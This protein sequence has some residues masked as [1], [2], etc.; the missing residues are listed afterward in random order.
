MHVYLD[1][2]VH[3][4]AHLRVAAHLYRDS[5]RINSRDYFKN[6]HTGRDPYKSY[7]PPSWSTGSRSRQCSTA[8]TQPAPPRSAAA[9]WSAPIRDHCRINSRDDLRNAQTRR[10]LGVLMY[11]RSVSLA[12]ELRDRHRQQP[13]RTHPK[14]RRVPLRRGERRAGR[15]REPALG[16]RWRPRRRLAVVTASRR[17]GK[18]KTHE[19]LAVRVRHC[20]VAHAPVRA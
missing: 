20:A 3:T 7:V 18:A 13:V 12:Q 5:L 9:P 15:R 1:S 8:A 2:E 6:P 10:L 14:P 4:A 16:R 19:V 17:D 11:L